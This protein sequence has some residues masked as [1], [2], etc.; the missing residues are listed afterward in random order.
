[1]PHFQCWLQ[2]PQ[3]IVVEFD[4]DFYCNIANGLSFEKIVNEKFLDKYCQ[5]KFVF[6]AFHPDQLSFVLAT[7]NFD[8]EF[9]H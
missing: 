3:I 1:M 5:T 2:R 8:Q 7:N 4:C 9:E 6:V